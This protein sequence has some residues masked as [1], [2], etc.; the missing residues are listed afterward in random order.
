MLG[1]E[2]EG[3][4]VGYVQLA[5]VDR[6]ERRAAVAIMLGDRATW[7]RGVGRTALRNLADY[8]FAALDLERVYA[9]VYGFNYRSQRLMERVG[10]R[11]EGILRQHELHNGVRQDVHVFDLL[12]ADFYQRYPT[13]FAMPDPAVPS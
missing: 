5:L 9:E 8:A 13:L 6:I 1:V 7:G 2:R 11:R 10:F 12:K 4:L 3:R